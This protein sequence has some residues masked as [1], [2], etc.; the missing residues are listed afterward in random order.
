MKTVNKESRLAFFSELYESGMIVA[1]DSGFDHNR[2][3]S[4]NTL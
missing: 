2:S 1:L 3:F 4:F